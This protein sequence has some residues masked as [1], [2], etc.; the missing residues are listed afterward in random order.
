[1]GNLLAENKGEILQR[2][3]ILQALSQMW[4]PYFMNILAT[5]QI[6]AKFLQ[7]HKVLQ[8][9]LEVLQSLMT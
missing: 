4:H 6:K 1:M 9:F 8:G 3:K 5:R 7:R 2:G